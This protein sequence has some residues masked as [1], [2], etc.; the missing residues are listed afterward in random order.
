MQ[1]NEQRPEVLSADSHIVEPADLFVEMI[2]PRFRD[3]APR[4]IEDP[5]FGTIWDVEGLGFPSVELM[6]GAGRS[7]EEIELEARFD[8][9]RQGGWDP[10]ER[11]RDMDTTGIHGAL[12]YPT[13]GFHCYGIADTELMTAVLRAW[14]DWIAD[15]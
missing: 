9:A 15:F 4:V 12:L 8:R 1:A 3:R 2:E 7:I 5:E 6:G 13:I 10:Q 11:L 14:N